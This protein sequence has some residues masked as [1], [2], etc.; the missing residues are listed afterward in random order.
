MTIHT[1]H[2]FATAEPERDPLR[3]FRGRLPLPVT[4]WTTAYEEARAG[5]TVSSMLVAPGEPAEL[6]GLLDEDSDLAELLARSSTV[7]V[8]LLGPSHRQLADAFAGLAPAPGGPF[9]LGSWT[10][11]PWGPV[12]KGAVGW[13]GAR[14]PRQSSDRAGWALLVRGEI[15]QVQ[16]DVGSEVLGYLRGRY[17]SLALET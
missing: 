7:A 17:Q 9:R 6:V 16:V 2:P 1:G 3:R 8:S 10:E 12:L 5:W 11:T 15:E 13:L 14:L 4:V